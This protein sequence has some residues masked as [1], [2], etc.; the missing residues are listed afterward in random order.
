MPGLQS[1]SKANQATS[2]TFDDPSLADFTITAVAGGTSIT[3]AAPTTAS[4]NCFTVSNG[5]G[6]INAI[7]AYPKVPGKF[8][9]FMVDI[10]GN[11]FC[12]TGLVTVAAQAAT[13]T[14]QAVAAVN[15]F[16]NTY[17]IGCTATATTA[18]TGWQ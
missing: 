16:D 7:A 12:E 5:V 4:T 17:N 10:S 6:A 15:G 1:A 11:K 18:V 8:P 9:K 13:N 3:T 2:E 14:S